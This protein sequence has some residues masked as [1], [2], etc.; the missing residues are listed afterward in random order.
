MTTKTICDL[1]GERPEK[2]K[3]S[4]RQGHSVHLC[5]QCNKACKLARMKVQDIVVRVAQ[6]QEVRHER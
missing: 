3:R 1:C 4:D 6:K 5:E 2:T